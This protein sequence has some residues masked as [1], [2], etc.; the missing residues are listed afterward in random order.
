MGRRDYFDIAKIAAAYVGTVI[1]AGFASGQELLQFFAQ[2]GIWGYLGVAVAT[3]GFAQ[4][5]SY[6]LDLGYR[7]GATGYYQILYH[8]CG[9]RIGAALDGCTIL[10]L[11]GG[12]CIML[13]G[14]GTVTRDFMG[15]PYA[16]GLGI[17]AV[18]LLITTIF[19]VN[20][21]A[22]ANLIVIPLLVITTICIGI[23]SISYHG[24]AE[25]LRN[26]LDVPRP[27]FTLHWFGSSMMYLSYNL[28]LGATILAPLGRLSCI[29]K[30]RQAGGWAGGVLLGLLSFW[31]TAL[32]L[33]HFDHVSNSEVPMLTLTHIQHPWSYWL[34]ASVLLGAM[35]T[36]AL[37]SLYGT[38]EKL[39]HGLGWSLRKAIV[40]I[41]LASLLFSQFGFARLISILYPMFGFLSCWFTLRLIWLGCRG[42]L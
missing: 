36:T 38:A 17:M 35:Y 21:I 34:Y 7:L 32:I 4:L 16:A 14:T 11:F 3:W 28:V 27:P 20:C 15:L 1:G 31:I 33:M 37:A 30:V 23:Y 9:K 29:K 18:I 39:S 25:S 40:L 26:F 2:Y 24:V 12:L 42:N 41:L 6:I 19:G 8:I 10:F 5:G 13:A 22:L